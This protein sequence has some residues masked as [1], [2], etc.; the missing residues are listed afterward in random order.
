VVQQS[1]SGYLVC[2]LFNLNSKKFEVGL[3]VWLEAGLETGLAM[4]IL[5]V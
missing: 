5:S 3:V 1:V 2:A 4:F